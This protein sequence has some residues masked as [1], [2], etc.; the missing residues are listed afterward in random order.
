MCVVLRD[1]IAPMVLCSDGLFV[2][3]LALDFANLSVCAKGTAYGVACVCFVLRNMC[4]SCRSDGPEELGVCSVSHDLAD[5]VAC[6]VSE[7]ERE[8]EAVQEEERC[9]SC[10]RH[11][12]QRSV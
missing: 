11:I 3:A 4:A 6:M 2:C 5:S 7:R 12:A 8:R 10:D 9:C 1:M